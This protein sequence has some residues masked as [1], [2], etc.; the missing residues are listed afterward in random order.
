MFQERLVLDNVYAEYPNCLLVLDVSE[1]PVQR[2]SDPEMQ[3]LLFS[4]KKKKHT[5]KYECKICNACLF[6]FCSSL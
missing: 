4:G 1:C 5:V 3:R 2:P 6:C